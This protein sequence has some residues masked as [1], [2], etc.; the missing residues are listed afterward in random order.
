MYLSQL[1]I[2][3]EKVRVHFLNVV[4][5]Y[6]KHE[7]ERQKTGKIRKKARINKIYLWVN[8]IIEK[9]PRKDQVNNRQ[10]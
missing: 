1:S 4:N 9:R 2:V 3:F 5:N 6:G 7:K 8:R 10:Q